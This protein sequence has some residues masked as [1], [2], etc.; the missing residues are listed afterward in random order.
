MKH[1]KLVSVLLLT[2]VLF[3]VSSCGNSSAPSDTL[4]TAYDLMKSKDFEKVIKLYV[5]R[6][7]EKF[8]EEEA[9]KLEGFIGMSAKKEFDSKEGLKNIVIDEEIIEDDGLS[10]NIKYTVHFK[11]G[12]T[13]KE[14]VKLIKIDGKWYII[15]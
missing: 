3:C 2:V 11:N 10:A 14:E 12:D 5:N 15:A 13:D 4:K 1:L 7:G 9:K 6:D 8:S